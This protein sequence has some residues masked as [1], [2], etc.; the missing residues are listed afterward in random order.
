MRLERHFSVRPDENDDWLW[1]IRA[2]FVRCLW[3]CLK[4]VVFVYEIVW[5]YKM[6]S[7]NVICDL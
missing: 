4:Y 3:L 1:E 2:G 7:F 5:K 6:V